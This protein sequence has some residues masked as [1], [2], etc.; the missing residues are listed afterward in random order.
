MNILYI[1]PY[2]QNNVIGWTS[3]SLLQHLL[4]GKKHNI[5]CRPIYL[6]PGNS[7][8][9]ISTSII[10]AEQIVNDSY[11]IIIQHSDIDSLIKIHSIK[12]NIAIPILQDRYIDSSTITN[13]STF[14]QILVDTKSDYQRLQQ[15]QTIKNKVKTYDYDVAISG[16]SNSTFRIG[17]LECAKKIYF[18]GKYSNNIDNIIHICKAFIHNIGMHE[19]VLL[20]FLFDLDTSKKNHIESIINKYYMLHDMRH[21]INRIVIAPIETALNDLFVAHQTGDIFLDLQDDHSNTLNT[22]IAKSLNKQIVQFDYSDIVFGFDR[23][24]QHHKTGFTGVSEEAINIAINN[25]ILNYR[26]NDPQPFKKENILNLI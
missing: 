13:L 24:G 12:K 1:G 9:N 16:K 4:S 17:V 10:D 7:T 22:K 21:T 3:A 26:N 2:R 18:V 6:E 11:D 19:Y 8:T 14:D 5:T 15:Y 25:C 20:L 23:N